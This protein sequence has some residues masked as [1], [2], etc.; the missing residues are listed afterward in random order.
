MGALISGFFAGI[1]NWL[2][3]GLA[4]IAACLIGVFIYR[5]YEVDSLTTQLQAA[6]NS[7]I[8]AQVQ[9]HAISDLRIQELKNQ[10]EAQK[11]A[12]QIRK[13]PSRDDG[14]VAPVLRASLSRL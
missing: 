13:T 5:G 8:S 4:A 2:Y 14:A 10:K 3:L 7:A 6:K 11:R 12:D 1:G 9:V